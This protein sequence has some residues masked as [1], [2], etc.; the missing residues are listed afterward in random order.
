MHVSLLC[1]WYCGCESV[2]LCVFMCAP[3]FVNVVE[4]ECDWVRMCSCVDCVSACMYMHV[5]VYEDV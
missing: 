2:C 4:Y 3:V 1:V 5:T